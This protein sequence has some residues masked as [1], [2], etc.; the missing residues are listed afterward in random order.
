MT[1]RII[2]AS[3]SEA[4]KKLLEKI[5]LDFEI[6]P[7]N[8]EEV[9]TPETPPEELAVELALGKAHNVAAKNTNAV[10]IAA[11]SFVILDGEY[12]SKPHSAEEA[13]AM[14]RKISGKKQSFVTGMAIIDTDSDKTFTDFEISEIW[15]KEISDN[16]IENYIKT[17]E[18]FSKAGGYA[19]QE[20]G[21]VF[22]E[23]VHGSYTSIVGLPI[24]KVYKILTELG[25]KVI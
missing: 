9:M 7:S 18:P 12:L 5:K 15:I 6:Q 8:Y 3:G 2:L 19:I 11:D 25:V 22:I 4:R 1:K 23:K 16:E 21:S 20:I 17:G 13:R 14:L 24:D 10:I